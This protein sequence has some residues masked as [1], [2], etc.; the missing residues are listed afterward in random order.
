MSATEDRHKA[1]V[2]IGGG[3][4]KQDDEP[5]TAEEME[6]FMTDLA[7]WLNT[8]GLSGAY[9]IAPIVNPHEKKGDNSP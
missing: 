5:W 1:W 8:R 7:A 9:S 2:T 3:F 4:F 6:A